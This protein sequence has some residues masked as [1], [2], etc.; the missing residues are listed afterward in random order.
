[1]SEANHHITVFEH[2][3][4]RFDKGER[5]ITREQFKALE[6]H[7]GEVG[8][9]YYSLCYNGVRFNEY[10]GVI[11]VGRTTIEVLPKADKASHTISEEAKWRGILID[12]LKAVGS[13]DIETRTNSSL[14][15]KSN[16]ILDLYFELFIKEVEWLLHNGLVKKYREKEG[17]VT[18]L[19]GSLQF[20]KHIQQNLTHQERFYVRHTTYDTT[21]ELHYIIYKTIRLLQQINT[22]SALHSRIS[23]LLL[24]FPEMPDMKVSDQTFDKILY[25]RKTLSYKKAIEIAR[26]LLLQYHPDISKG[27][28]HVLA[29]MFDMNKLWEQFVYI[30]I[31]KQKHLLTTVTAQNT[32]SFWQPQ[33]GSKSTIRPDVVIKSATHCLVLDTKWKNLSGYNPSTNDL[34]QMYVYHEYYEAH[35]VALVYPGD[36]AAST[37]GIFFDKVSGAAGTM[38]CSVICIPVAT[39]VRLWQEQIRLRFEGMMAD[40]L[41]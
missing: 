13:F 29:L 3:T 27:R 39:N 36:A 25:N 4:V 18:A 8:V 14:R 35:K 33:S 20:G 15:L 34:R 16:S 24:N 32:K 10:V 22:H 23:S 28:N 5:K 37:S 30:S 12:M 19:K 26:L 31:R 21:H 17:N 40:E 6:R 9:P 2:E 38:Q 11:Q 1:M 7:F 41:S